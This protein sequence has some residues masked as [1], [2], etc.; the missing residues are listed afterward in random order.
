[1]HLSK[2]GKIQP[3]QQ[4]L[5]LDQHAWYMS[6]LGARTYEDMRDAPLPV[7]TPSGRHAFIAVCYRSFFYKN[8]VYKIWL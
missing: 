1:M 5:I 4:L 7:I 3:S 8:T 6:C 2:F